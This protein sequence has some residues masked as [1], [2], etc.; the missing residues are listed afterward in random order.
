MTIEANPTRKSCYNRGIASGIF[1]ALTY[2]C[3]LAGS[4][5][6]AAIAAF[7]VY[8]MRS[9]ALKGRDGC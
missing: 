3:V 7:M 6:Y 9:A 4:F 8:S 2:K 5:I 1:L